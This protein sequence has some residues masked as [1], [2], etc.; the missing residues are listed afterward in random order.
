MNDKE[1]RA[2]A[3]LEIAKAAVVGYGAPEVD[4]DDD[5]DDPVDDVTEYAIE[6]ADAVLEGY[7]Q[8]FGRAPVKIVTKR[9]RKKREEDS[10]E[11]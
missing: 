11:E 1:R 4:D 8:R 7:E 6:V 3:W 10:E 5:D 2:H 9:G